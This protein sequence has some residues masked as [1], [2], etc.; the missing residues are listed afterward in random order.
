MK[1][2]RITNRQDEYFDFFWKLYESAFPLI[3]RRSLDYQIETLNQKG[4]TL[5]VVLEGELPIGFISWWE[6][7]RAIYVEHF[8]IDPSL[9]GRSYGGKLL[10]D[11]MDTCAKP[12]ILEVEHPTDDISTRRIGFYERLGFVLNHH[13]YAH[14]SYQSP[15]E[16]MVELMIMS[17]PSQVTA[18]ELENFKVEAFPMVHF[19]NAILGV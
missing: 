19:R 7:S 17:Y 1:K 9:R 8:A 6:M 5:E 11:F 10:T 13:P 3:E 16:P 12:I 14:P 4:Y 2:H 15:D 18:L